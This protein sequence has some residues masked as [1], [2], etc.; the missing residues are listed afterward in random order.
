MQ[1][2][3]TARLLLRDWIDEDLDAFERL[4]ADPAVA[5]W[6]AGA[7]TRRQA[8]AALAAMR[9]GNADHGWG[10]RAVCLAD[11]GVLIGA[12][13]L[14]AVRA[15]MP[16]AGIEATWRLGSAWWGAGYASEAMGALLDDGFARLPVDEFVGFTSAANLRS[17][18][19]MRRLGFVA[20]PA[21]DFDH[22]RLP[23]GHPLRRHVFYRR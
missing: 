2:I 20:E 17:Q 10:V 12:A 16:F 22:P 11:D 19:V 6:L 4:H 14:Q 7:L 23:E 9:R 18:A 1:P 5:R 21:R 3:R 8:A 15:G 13:G